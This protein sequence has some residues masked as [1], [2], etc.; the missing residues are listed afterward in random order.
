MDQTR[1]QQQQQQMSS[2]L[3]RDDFDQLLNAHNSSS[4][5][6]Q[7]FG[8]FMDSLDSQDV[9]SNRPGNP[10]SNLNVKQESDAG[11]YFGHGE[12]VWVD[13]FRE[14]RSFSQ[15]RRENEYWRC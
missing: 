7:A 14:S 11:Y 8:R 9:N 4:D 6:Q 15:Q 2:G 5:I 13:E 12:F 10:S 3:T 1:Y